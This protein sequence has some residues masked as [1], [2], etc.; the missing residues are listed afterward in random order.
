MYLNNALWKLLTG[1]DPLTARDLY[2]SPHKFIPTSQIIVLT[3]YL[4]LFD[5]HDNAT[6]QR[7][8]IVP[9]LIEHK[10]GDKE[11]IQ[12]DSFKEE[13]KPEYPGIVK[14]FAE[15]YIKLKQEHNGAIPLSDECK[16][17]KQLYIEELDTDLDRFVKDNIEFVMEDNAF[18]ETQAVY[19]RYLKYYKFTAEDAGKEALTRQKFT[20]YLKRDYKQIVQKQKKINGKPELCFFNIRLKTDTGQTQEPRPEE[21]WAT[22]PARHAPPPD[23]NPF[24]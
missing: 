22:K 17:Y 11:L 4:P 14:L 5:S 6:I 10:R 13:I 12:I 1:G 15:Y 16:R 2:Q 20:R 19:E 3:N 7:M 24:E 9:F 21:P 8:I 18:E 23:E